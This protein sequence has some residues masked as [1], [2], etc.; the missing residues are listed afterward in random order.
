VLLLAADYQRWWELSLRFLRGLS[1]AE[2]ERVLGGN[3]R[4][5][6]R[7]EAA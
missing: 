3:A 6:Y 1:A 2:Q 4:D 5:F 7:L